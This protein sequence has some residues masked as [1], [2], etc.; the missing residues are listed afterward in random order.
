MEL[1]VLRCA[2]PPSDPLVAFWSGSGRGSDEDR[3]ST[4]A[5]LSFLFAPLLRLGS[6]LLGLTPL[7]APEEAPDKRLVARA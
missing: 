5:T 3:P 2:E 1:V 7:A 6:I 4:V